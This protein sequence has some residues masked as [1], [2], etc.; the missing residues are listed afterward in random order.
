MYPRI[1]SRV[2]GWVKA[3]GQCSMEFEQRGPENCVMVRTW[4]MSTIRRVCVAVLSRLGANTTM[5]AK[6]VAKTLDAAGPQTFVVSLQGS[7]AW[8]R[9][10]QAIWEV[11]SVR[12]SWS[13]SHLI[14]GYWSVASSELLHPCLRAWTRFQ[15]RIVIS[16]LNGAETQDWMASR[17]ALREAIIRNELSMPILVDVVAK[18]VGVW[19]LVASYLKKTG[20]KDDGKSLVVRSCTVSV[21]PASCKC[22][23]HF[24]PV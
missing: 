12:S 4:E 9:F 24:F 22:T 17:P 23:H 2:F 10:L 18:I 20:R 6:F 16:R 19:P 21:L 7:Q 15:W 1:L 5:E 14:S 13:T 8:Q 11:G 3:H